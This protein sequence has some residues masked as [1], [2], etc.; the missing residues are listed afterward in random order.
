MN[1]MTIHAMP[2]KRRTRLHPRVNSIGWAHKKAPGSWIENRPWRTINFSFIVQGTGLY[3]YNDHEWRVTAPAL[4][5]QWPTAKLSYG[6]DVNW[7]EMYI[8]Y[9]IAEGQRFCQ[10]LN[11]DLK[12]MPMWL[13]RDSRHVMLLLRQVLDI[14]RSDAIE[15]QG[16]RLDNICQRMV[17]EALL[18]QGTSD[19][20]HAVAA[21]QSIRQMTEIHPHHDFNFKQLA[22]EHGL[23][24]TH[25][26]RLWKQQL[27]MS[28]A[29][30]VTDIRMRRACRLL[31]ETTLS[32]QT[33]SQQL[34]FDDSLYFSRRFKQLIGKSPLHYR[35]Q[36]EI[37]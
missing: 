1:N 37:E 6:P 31:T 4:I 22:A 23:S 33:I 27:G 18:A 11:L 9:P 26:R 5:T 20:S 13:I 7:Q 16:D 3:R 29:A 21:V 24:Y 14:M 34:G 17:L 10:Q 25:F 8:M 12:T 30:Y 32:I 15:H 2:L 36:T 35:Q 28:P 19:L